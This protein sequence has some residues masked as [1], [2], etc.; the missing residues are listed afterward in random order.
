MRAEIK[1]ALSDP[2]LNP[3]QGLNQRQLS[4]ALGADPQ[5]GAVGAGT[6]RRPPLNLCLILDH[7]GSMGGEPIRT[8]RQAAQGIVDRLT[9]QDRIS[10]V[11]FDHRASVLVPNQPVQDPQSIKAQI[12]TLKAGGGT[13]ID[14]GMKL[15]LETAATGKQGA[16]S[17]VFLLT[18]GENEHGDNQ[19]CLKLAQ[20]SADYGLTLHGL[21]FGDHWN[22]DILEQ[23]ADAGGGSLSYIQQPNAAVETFSQLLNRAQAVGLTNAYLQLQLGA[24][25]RLAELKPIAQVSPDTV[26]LMAVNAGDH[27]EVRLGDLQVDAPRVVLVNLYVTPPT[28]GSHTLGQIQLHYD[29]PAT[30]Q[31]GLRSDIVSVTATIPDHYQPQIDPQVEKQVLTLAKY[32]QTQIAET[33]L[34]AGDAKGAATLLQSAAKTALQ[35]GDNQAATVLQ[36]NATR[37]Q[38]GQELSE[39]DRKKTRIVSKTTLQ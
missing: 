31:A 34:K 12:Q 2:N 9:P 14:D 19:R 10:V 5:M 37:L 36:E 27:Y 11:G 33:K 1:W 8:V 24:G 6:G 22:Q 17:Q 25:V 4:L 21:G 28:S 32:R 38:S 23:I 30:G 16:V 26:E 29:D 39:R 15:G 3:Q 35:M 13:A 20:L 7:S 18:D